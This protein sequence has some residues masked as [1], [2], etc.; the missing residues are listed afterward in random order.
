MI[1]LENKSDKLPNELLNELVDVH[2]HL[3]HPLLIDRTNEIISR[4][5]KLGLKWILS[6]GLNPQT[7]RSSLELSE[8]YLIVKCAM[9]LYPGST[10]KS[11]FDIDKEISYIRENKDKL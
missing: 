9:G 3:D 5:K 1:M 7:N 4:A 11:D 6:N 2:A 8:K 10:L